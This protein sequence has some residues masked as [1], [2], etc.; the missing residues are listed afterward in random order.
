MIKSDKELAEAEMWLS[1]A[2]D[3]IKGCKKELKYWEAIVVGY[4]Q[5]IAEYKMFGKISSMEY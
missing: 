1:D 3:E 5:Q 4:E 2:Q